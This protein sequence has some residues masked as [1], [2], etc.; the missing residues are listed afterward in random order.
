[1]MVIIDYGMGNVGSIANMLKKIG[2]KAVVASDVSRIENAR[3]LILPG[4]GAFDSGMR[5]LRDSGLIDVLTR[6]VTLEKVP[7]L[8]ICLGMQLMT[9]SSEEGTSAGLGWIDAETVRFRFGAEDKTLR[10]PH[11]GWNT[12]LPVS[13]STLFDNTGDEQRFYFVHS[14]HVVCDDEADVAAK[15]H[16]GYDFVSALQ[17]ENI[18]GVQFH[19]EKSH[20]FGMKLLMNFAGI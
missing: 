19:P 6:K 18:M 8:G 11:M 10:I 17:K 5:N 9:R 3:G 16:Y 14:Y 12:V 7:V 15:T 20:R 13:E 2:A 4:V 1:M